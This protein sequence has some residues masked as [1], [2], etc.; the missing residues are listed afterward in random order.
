M[1]RL[2]P[3]VYK[4][5]LLIGMR[6]GLSSDMRLAVGVV[7]LSAILFWFLTLVDQQ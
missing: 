2:H 1:R 7:A 4:I 5:P 6:S 3:L